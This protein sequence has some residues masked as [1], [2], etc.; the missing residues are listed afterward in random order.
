MGYVE[1]R[2]W[3]PIQSPKTSLDGQSNGSRRS[4]SVSKRSADRLVA[5]TRKM[6]ELKK[7]ETLLKEKRKLERRV[8]LAERELQRE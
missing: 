1:E 8:K 3:C 5:E 6:E 2:L 7:M 4:T